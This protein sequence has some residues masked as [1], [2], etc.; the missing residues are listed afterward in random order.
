MNKKLILGSFLLV[1]AL[2]VSAGCTTFTPQPAPTPTPTPVIT[3]E[4]PTTVPTTVAPVATPTASTKPEPTQT[5]PSQWALSISVEKA[6]TYS[7]TIITHF[8]GGKGLP[9]VLKME[10]RVTKPDGSVVSKTIERPKM[11]DVIEIEGTNSTDRVE[12]YV[13]MNSGTVYKIIDQQMP[14]KTR[15]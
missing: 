8:D 9:S 15:G 11:G 6:G 14:Y 3:T 13:T 4:I 7:M 12:V 1:I 10:S 5:L 2:L